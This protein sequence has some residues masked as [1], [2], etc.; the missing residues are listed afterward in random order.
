MKK[1]HLTLLFSLAVLAA[2]S[3]KVYFFYIQTE[4]SQPFYLKLDKKIQYSSPNGYIILPKL[5][6]SSYTFS[7]GFPQDKWP[8]QSFAVNVN[9]KDHGY[10]LKSIPDKGWGLFDMQSLEL[11][12]AVNNDQ[13]KPENG[14]VTPF[15]ELLS[16]A[17]DDPT[18]KEK[19]VQAKPD[20]KKPEETVVTIEPTKTESTPVQ[21]AGADNDKLSKKAKRKAKLENKEAVIV[22]PAPQQAAV[23]EEDNKAAKKTKKSKKDGEAEKETKSEQTTVVS[24]SPPV[25]E[26]PKPEIK[27]EVK[28]VTKE[29]KPVVNED[30]KTVTEEKPIVKEEPKPVVTETEE[31]KKSLVKRYSESSTT[32]GFGLVFVDQYAN[33]N[34]DTI[35]LVIPNPKPVINTVP[36]TPKEEKK[37]LEINTDPASKPVVKTNYPN[38]CAEAASEADLSKLSRKMKTVNDSE[39]KMIAEARKYFKTACFS[40]SQVK[41]LGVHFINDEARYNFFDLAYKYVIDPENFVDLQSELKEVYYQS[42]FKAMLRN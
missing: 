2:S 42:R 6:D 33:G 35:R 11:L 1:L 41:E 24:N 29:E 17:A 9:K 3:Q 20:E 27:E 25:K 5:Y 32:E 14:A 7:I 18:L 12:M 10:L 21:T 36:E 31:Y 19:T 22:E 15:T 28:P 38:G 26:E 34:K 16:K 37:F 4:S 8:E 30:V 40:S 39:E 23:N 13:K